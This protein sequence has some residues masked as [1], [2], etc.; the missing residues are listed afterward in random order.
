MKLPNPKLPQKQSPNSFHMQ[1]AILSWG[2]K[3]LIL[4]IKLWSV[5]E[6]VKVICRNTIIGSS[7]SVAHE[8]MLVL[9]LL[10]NGLIFNECAHKIHP[11]VTSGGRIRCSCS[12]N[13]RQV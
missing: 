6:L 11:M 9:G 5:V 13:Q 4:T 7:G 2:S 10:L 12:N 1:N 3:V 8:Q